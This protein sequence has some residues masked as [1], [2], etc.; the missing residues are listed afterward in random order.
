MS[1]PE[2]GDLLDL[3][4]KQS[5]QKQRGPVPASVESYDQSTQTV[6]AKPLVQP[7]VNGK[8]K[9]LPVVVQVPVFFPRSSSGEASITWPIKVGDTVYL[10]PAEMDISAWFVR[11]VSEAP[12]ERRADLS[13]SIALAGL[14]NLSDS[15][16]S[17][18]F[19]VDALVVRAENIYLGSGTASDYVALASL[20]L[21]ELQA[22]KTWVDLH[23]HTGGTLGGGLT[24][25]P[26][27]LPSPTPS[28]PAS[29]KV[30]SE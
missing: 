20:V 13:D 29:S 1:R 19:A 9:D 14:G 10:V 4:N 18:A 23:T 27:T 5:S 7:L 15:L 16:P 26:A 21:G 6:N 17:D 8:P 12:T 25:V 3:T 22:M 28:S 24:G 2:L 11:G 30:R